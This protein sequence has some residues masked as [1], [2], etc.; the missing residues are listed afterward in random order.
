MMFTENSSTGQLLLFRRQRVMDY[1]GICFGITTVVSLILAYY[2]HGQ[3][4]QE[5][6]PTYHVSPTRARIVDTSV[7]APPQLQVLYKGKGLNANVSAAIV[8]FWNDGKLPIKSEDVLEPVKIELEP[9]CEIL[10]SRVLKVSRPLTSLNK[11]EVSDGAKNVLPLSFRILE[12][13]DGAVLQIIYS[14]KPE[15]RLTVTGAV[16]GS[17][18]PKEVFSQQSRPT[19]IRQRPKRF[20]A[21]LALFIGGNLL[22]AVWVFWLYHSHRPVRSLWLAFVFGQLVAMGTGVYVAYRASQ[23]VVPSTIWMNQ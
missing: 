8:Y 9:G 21:L 16:I 4:I 18:T 17:G 11:G 23:P 6:A 5:R 7:P 15:A 2:W 13:N 19:D 10:D 12:H 22:S 20:V 1:L 3:S 14:G